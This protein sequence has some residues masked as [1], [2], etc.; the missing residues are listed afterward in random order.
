MPDHMTWTVSSFLYHIAI[1]LKNFHDQF[2]HNSNIPLNCVGHKM[3]RLGCVYEIYAANV[4]TG[5]IYLLVIIKVITNKPILILTIIICTFRNIKQ[6]HTKWTM[7]WF[8]SFKQHCQFFCN[9]KFTMTCID[10]EMTQNYYAE[11]HNS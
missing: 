4:K 6:S 7:V 8:L 3:K 5:T 1:M 9:G 2:L 10:K 11:L